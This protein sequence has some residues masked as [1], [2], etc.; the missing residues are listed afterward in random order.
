MVIAILAAISIVAYNGIQARANDSAMRNAAA[1]VEKALRLYVV[2]NGSTIN[3]GIDSTAVAAGSEC[4]DGKSGWFGSAS[5]SCT[6]EDTL[7]AAKLLPKDFAKGLPS[8]PYLSGTTGRTSMM[9]Y[10]C[11]STP[12]LYALYWTLRL[13]TVEESSNI[14]TIVSTCANTQVR[15]TWGMRAGKILQ[16]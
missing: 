9:L 3:G 6:A 10:K 14:D 7:V 11:G 1:Q 8:N 2:D 4:V 12:G 15:D 13:P 5:Y 16:L